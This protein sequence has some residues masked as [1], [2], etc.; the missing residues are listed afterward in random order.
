MPSHCYGTGGNPN[1]AAANHIDF[2]VKWNTDVTGKENQ[3]AHTVDTEAEATEI[4][5]DI[6]RTKPE[7]MLDGFDYVEASGSRNIKTVSGFAFDNVAIYNGLASAGVDAV[8]SEVDTLDKCLLHPTGSS[9]GNM[10]HYHSLGLCM[11]PSSWTSTTDVPTLC[12]SKASPECVSKPFEWA[13]A[14]WSDKNNFGGEVGLARDGHVIVGPWNADGELWSCEDHDVCNG[15]FIA[16]GSYV[17]VTTSTFPYVVG[18]WG[19]GTSDY[20]SVAASCSTNSCSTLVAGGIVQAVA[21]AGVAATAIAAN[22]F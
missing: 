9:A 22:L 6:T 8:T 13:L 1:H 10:L 19:P 3:M 14:S 20:S 12:D 5:C 17:Y 18:C 21:F 4:L 15:T 16:D 11:K 2:E 7:N